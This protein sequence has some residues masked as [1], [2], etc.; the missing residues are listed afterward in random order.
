VERIATLYKQLEQHKAE[1][2]HVFIA[3]GAQIAIPPRVQSALLGSSASGGLSFDEAC[4]ELTAI[5]KAFVQVHKEEATDK[6]EPLEA[7]IQAL[8]MEL[9]DLTSGSEEAQQK[10]QALQTELRE[11]T[12]NSEQE[13]QKGS[14]EAR[15]NIEALQTELMKLTSSSEQEQ[16]KGSDEAR[17]N[18]EA[19][20]TELMKLTSSSEEAQQKAAVRIEELT[21]MLEEAV[22]REVAVQHALDK[23]KAK[24][25]KRLKQGRAEVEHAR[26][27][28]L[29][30]MEMSTADAGQPLKQELVKLRGELHAVRE[31]H[32]AEMEG[33]DAFLER[34]MAEQKA[35]L[36]GIQR[37]KSHTPRRN[38]MGASAPSTPRG[39]PV[40]TNTSVMP[41]FTP[42]PRTP[43]AISNGYGNMGPPSSRQKPLKGLRAADLDITQPDMEGM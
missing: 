26:Q 12:S 28:A 22:G 17:Q 42:T 37:I 30:E 40:A 24:H 14:D 34:K 10:I 19:L 38:T 35:H 8:Q 23:T 7:R 13:Q 5:I 4:E 32:A 33:K 29:L 18:V 31:S 36:E 9:K 41:R 39:S 1:F 15:Q 2:M 25:E 3:I 16:Q 21:G 6:S 43:F 27:E 20:Q 11:L